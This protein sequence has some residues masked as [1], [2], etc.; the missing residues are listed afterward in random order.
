V[1]QACGE[2][3][4]IEEEGREDQHARG[5]R[6]RIYEKTLYCFSGLGYNYRI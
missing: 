4:N 2:K 5:G 3:I 6:E 1:Q